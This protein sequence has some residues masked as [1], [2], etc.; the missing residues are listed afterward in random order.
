MGCVRGDQE[1]VCTEFGGVWRHGVASGSV[2]RQRK[3]RNGCSVVAEVRDAKRRFERLGKMLECVG[4]FLE[5]SIA[6]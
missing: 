1:I 6:L 2:G 3:R 5:C 4:V